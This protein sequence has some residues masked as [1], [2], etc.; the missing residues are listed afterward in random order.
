M[1]VSGGIWGITNAL[2]LWGAKFLQL[3]GMQ[4]ETWDFWQQDGW[5]EMLAN[6]VLSHQNSL[7]NFG[8]MIRAAIAAAVSG[9]WV[10]NKSISW[11]HVGVAFFGGILMGIGARMAE[12]CNIGAYLG[13]IASGSVSGWLWALAALVSTWAGLKA[14][15]L[16][17]L[18]NPARLIR[19]ADSRVW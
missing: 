16:V 3:F 18:A 4:P 17:G 1:W 14:R 13:G 12:G 6:P 10:L 15:S 5:S 8:I 19:S 11:G 9:S 2:A 7:T